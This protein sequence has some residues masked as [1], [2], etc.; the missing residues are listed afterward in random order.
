MKA[1]RNIIRVLIVNCDVINARGL[2]LQNHCLLPSENQPPKAIVEPQTRSS[3]ILFD[4]EFF[5]TKARSLGLTRKF[6][7]KTK[8]V[9]DGV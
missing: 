9:H 2:T 4:H 6:K 1:S 7:K 5:T 8:D 3:P